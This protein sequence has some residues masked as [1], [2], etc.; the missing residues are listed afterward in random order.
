[1]KE[2]IKDKT[3]IICENELKISILKKITNTFFDVKFYT[4]N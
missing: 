3:I 2:F 4:K 1:M